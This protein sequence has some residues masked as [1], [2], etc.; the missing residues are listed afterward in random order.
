MIAELSKK[1]MEEGSVTEQR[2]QEGHGGG[3]GHGAA[4]ARAAEV[5]RDTAAGVGR[6]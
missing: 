3:V 5:V 1:A 6:F 4:S 2:Q